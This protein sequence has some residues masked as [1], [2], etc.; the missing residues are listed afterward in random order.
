MRPIILL[1][2][3]L[4]I[5]PPAM[6]NTSIPAP[7][8]NNLT[9]LA[10]TQLLLVLAPLMRSYTALTQTP[11]SVAMRDPIT[12]ETQIE[13]GLEAHVL[14]TA[15]HALIDRLSAQGLTNV[16]SRR[17]VARTQ[18]ALITTSALNDQA[19]FAR[20]ISFAAMLYATPTLPVFVQ[21]I[22][23][24]DGDRANAL[25]VGHEFSSMLA[26][27]IKSN[28]TEEEV[29]ESLRDSNGLALML[30]STATAEPD[31][32]ILAQLPDDLSPPVTFDAVVLGS[33]S[34]N[35]ANA[36]V[37]YLNSQ[38]AQRIFTRYGFQPPAAH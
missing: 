9:I 6:A 34:M 29:L 33:E 23:S 20:R 37:A 19:T 35:D 22:G 30:A 18:L 4:L 12:T 15:N 3:A 26:Q 10:D 28:P 7:E 2:L 5:Q 32:R 8:K 27:R 14:I 16:T 17:T 21:A 13:Q 38:A 31:V 1:I 36:F 25:L 24:D 11:L